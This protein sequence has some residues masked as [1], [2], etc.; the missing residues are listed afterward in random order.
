MLVALWRSNPPWRIGIEV[1]C[2]G[3]LCRL[4]LATWFNRVRCPACGQRLGSSGR[5]PPISRGLGMRVRTAAYKLEPRRQYEFGSRLVLPPARGQRNPKANPPRERPLRSTPGHKCSAVGSGLRRGPGNQ[6]SATDQATLPSTPPVRSWV[7]RRSVAES[8]LRAPESFQ[9]VQKP[10]PPAVLQ[11]HLASE[12]HDVAASRRCAR[13]RTGSQPVVLELVESRAKRF[14]AGGV[15]GGER[16]AHERP[17][18]AGQGGR[19]ALPHRAPASGKWRRRRRAD[20]VG[21]AARIRAPHSTHRAAR[22]ET[23]WGGLLAPACA[24]TRGRQ[25]GPSKSCRPL[26]GKADAE[27]GGVYGVGAHD[28]AVARHVLRGCGEP[29]ARSPSDEKSSWRAAARRRSG[30]RFVWRRGRI[31][32]PP[33]RSC[34][35]CALPSTNSRLHSQ[36]SLLAAIRSASLEELVGAEAE[37]RARDTSIRRNPRRRASATRRRSAPQRRRRAGYTAAPPKRSPRYWTASSPW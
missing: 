4:A 17:I 25:R 12:V 9:D 37:G 33:P 7:S 27:P 21:R 13:S 11:E 1:V 10:D 28:S 31:V 26:P 14:V 8:A 2:I 29:L 18:P 23:P 6:V 5:R 24:S 30:A 36:A 32:Y 19:G 35:L 20:R 34:L 22:L 3:A 16:S 15:P